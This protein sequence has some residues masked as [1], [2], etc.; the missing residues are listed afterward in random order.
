MPVAFVPA[1]SLQCEFPAPGPNNRTRSGMPGNIDAH[2]S[3]RVAGQDTF[4]DAT[5]AIIWIEPL[6]GGPVP[7]APQRFRPLPEKREPSQTVLKLDL[8]PRY[9]SSGGEIVLRRVALLNQL[10]GIFGLEFVGEC[11][12]ELPCEQQF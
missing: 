3:V 10:S 5:S 4:A 12:D 7:E 11:L 1:E 6:D 9:A 2:A 8:F